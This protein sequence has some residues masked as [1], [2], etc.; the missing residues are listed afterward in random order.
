[1]PISYITYK[2]KQILF[3]DLTESKTEQRS[4]ELLEEAKK[5]FIEADEKLLVLT[6]TEGSF[7][8]TNVTT[9]MKEYGKMYFSKGAKRRAFVGITGVKKILFKAYMKIVGGEAKAFDS[10]RE[11]KEYLVS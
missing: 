10:L 2:D 3:I 5:Y 11:A 4:L 9:K 7:V 8:N 1:M 6:S